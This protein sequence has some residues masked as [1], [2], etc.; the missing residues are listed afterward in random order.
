M[1]STI[2]FHGF[3]NS[4]K[5]SFV[6]KEATIIIFDSHFNIKHMENFHIKTATLCIPLIDSITNTYIYRN[7]HALPP[8]TDFSFSISYYEFIR[9][10]RD[11]FRMFSVHT[12]SYRHN[13]P[14]NYVEN[15]FRHKFR[16][17]HM[18]W[19]LITNDSILGKG[20]ELHTL[21]DYH[22]HVLDY[23]ASTDLSY[24]PKNKG[25]MCTANNAYKLYLYLYSLN[26]EV[27]AEEET[28]PECE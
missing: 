3:V 1:Q 9:K 27:T 19:N 8:F 22:R 18:N 28:Q 26:K 11:I 4:E 20:F 14:F 2:T 21:C 13:M 10:I 5:Q 16:N 25:K 15:K 24:Q 17:L 12:V 6:L 23:S 7:V